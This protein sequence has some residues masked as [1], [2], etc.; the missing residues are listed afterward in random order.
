MSSR[1]GL[2]IPG[3]LLW[4][5]FPPVFFFIFLFLNF[6]FKF[7]LFSG[8]PLPLQPPEPSP[9]RGPLSPASPLQPDPPGGEGVAQP[10]LVM[11]KFFEPGRFGVC[12]GVLGCFLWAEGMCV[13]GA[14]VPLAGVLQLPPDRAT[15]G[16]GGGG[17]FLPT[18][19]TVF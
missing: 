13:C 9:A 6:V 4:F 1:G 7:P 14:A 2:F 8:L 16:R 10:P 18:S 12:L 19:Q 5:L 11:T 15:P 17:Q 3:T